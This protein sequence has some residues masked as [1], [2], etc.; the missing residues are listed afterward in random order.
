[1][2]CLGMDAR[3]I[4]YGTMGGIKVTPEANFTRLFSTRSS[5]IATTLRNR[6]DDYK[7]RL[8]SMFA[9]EIIPAFERQE[10]TPV[11]DRVMKLS[12]I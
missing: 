9:E 10:L 6:S 4:M 11:I 12:E 5:I 2:N 1:M 7:S 8:C 3:W